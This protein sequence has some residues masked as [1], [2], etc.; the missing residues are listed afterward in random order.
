MPR[1]VEN[2]KRVHDIAYKIGRRFL[3][4]CWRPALNRGDSDTTWLATGPGLVARA[5]AQVLAESENP[6]TWL[7]RNIVLER[8]QYHRAVAEHARVQYKRSPR[9]WSRYAFNKRRQPRN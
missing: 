5:F 8:W 3:E 6:D 7:E 9:H 4:I 2:K 1:A